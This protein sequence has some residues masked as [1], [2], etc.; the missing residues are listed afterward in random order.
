[1]DA[2]VG[3]SLYSGIIPGAGSAASGKSAFSDVT[4]SHRDTVNSM[5][6]YHPQLIIF[7]TARLRRRSNYCHLRM[8]VHRS[9]NMVDRFL[10]CS[11]RLQELYDDN[12]GQ[13]REEVQALS[14][15][16][17]FKEFYERFKGVKEFHR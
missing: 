1:M 13:R 9:R 11:S 6:R 16:N 3:E 7:P 14:G 15:P 5:H 17:E 2:M 4:L 12:D 8:I 10:E